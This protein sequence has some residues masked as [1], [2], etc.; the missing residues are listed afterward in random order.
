[1][2]RTAFIVVSAIMALT[3]IVNLV[4]FAI[5]NFTN[6]MDD[7]PEGRFLFSTMSTDPQQTYTVQLYHVSEED[8]L[9]DAVRAVRIT[10]ATGEKKNIYWVVGET[11]AMVTW[12]SEF[13]VVINDKKIDIRTQVYDWRYPR[14]VE[15]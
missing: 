9:K 3:V 1:M 7:L 11:N 2:K 6:D 15:G 10:N 5:D 14:V 8:S 4:F 12:D 13:T